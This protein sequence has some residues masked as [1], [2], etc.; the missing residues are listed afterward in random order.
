MTAGSDPPRPP[1]CSRCGS[2]MVRR[3]RRADGAAFLGCSTFPACRATLPITEES[4]AGA[5]AERVPVSAAPAAGASA[6]RTYGRRDERWRERI[7]TRGPW[8]VVATAGL[9]IAAIVVGS[10]LGYPTIGA[11]VGLAMAVTVLGNLLRSRQRVTAWRVGAEGEQATARALEGLPAG[12]LVLHDRRIP[13]GHANIDHVVVGPPGV[14]VIET[15]R[16]SGEVSIDGDT[17]RVDGRRREVVA[18]VRREAEA[19]RQLLGNANR[20][21]T[22]RPVI[23]VHD[24]DLPLFRRGVDGIP[25]VSGRGLV[26]TLENGPVELGPEDVT[27]IAGV[28]DRHLRPA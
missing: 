27:G 22:V 7:G 4:A 20:P 21:I 8:I 14:F 10:A 25:L 23:C 12:W 28:L 16:W 11:A 1:A 26:G 9:V 3:E 17:V 13:G 19:V 6:A 2:A 15:K 5:Q 24:A 18:Q